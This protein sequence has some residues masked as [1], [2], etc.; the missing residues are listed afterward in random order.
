MGW[1]GMTSNEKEQND[2]NKEFY[3]MIKSLPE[4]TLL[5]VVDCHI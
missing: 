3:D 4:D 2:W 1:F 5:T